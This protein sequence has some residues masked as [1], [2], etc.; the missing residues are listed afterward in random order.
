MGSWQIAV[1]AFL[2]AAVSDDMMLD[3]WIPD[4][5]WVRQIQE[6]GGTGC[7]VGNLNTGLALQ[8]VWQN[9]HATLHGRTVFYNKKKIRTSKTI[10]RANKNIRFYYVVGADKPAPIVPSDL[11]FYQSLWDDLDRST[12]SLKRTAPSQANK[13]P[14]VGRTQPPT[15]KAKAS[16]AAVTSP[17]TFNAALHML[18]TA[19]QTAYGATI[20]FPT[21]LIAFFPMEIAPSVSGMNILFEKN[22]TNST[23]M[24]RRDVQLPSGHVVKDVPFCYEL[25]TSSAWSARKKDSMIVRALKTVLDHKHTTSMLYERRLLAGWSDSRPQVATSNQE[26]LLALGWYSL[27]LEMKAEGECF[28][29]GQYV[30][31]SWLTLENDCNSSPSER[32][33]RRW[34]LDLAVENYLIH[35]RLVQKAPIFAQSDGGQKAQEVRLISFWN[36]EKSTAQNPDG[37]CELYWLDLA[38]TVKKSEDVAKGMKHLLRKFGLA[39]K[40]LRGSTSDSGVGNPKSWSKALD[41]EGLWEEVSMEDSCGIHYLQSVFRLALQHFVGEGSLD[42]EMPS[43]FCIQCFL[44]MTN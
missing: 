44:S 13:A 42:F 37:E 31:L 17:R 39:D 25:Y 33:L 8:R 30:N 7:S 16:S 38:Y 3:R 6:N 35:S 32:T 28:E 22:E 20:K 21:E 24:Q 1:K 15:K 34:V 2:D 5:D 4:E 23:P 29:G 40:K 26:Q 14:S 36:D 9:N 41:K 19:W 10:A 27:L 43:S 12:R 18:L 11:G